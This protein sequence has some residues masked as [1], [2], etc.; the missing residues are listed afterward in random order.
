MSKKSTI[1]KPVVVP[2]FKK[3]ALLKAKKYEG[4]RDLLNALLKDDQEYTAAEVAALVEEF[5][6]GKV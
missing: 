1:V 3:E 5:K 4:Q 6:K 2:K